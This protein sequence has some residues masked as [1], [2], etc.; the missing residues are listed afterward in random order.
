MLEF[1]FQI[2]Q[3]SYARTIEGSAS[4]SLQYVTPYSGLV[5]VLKFC[6]KQKKKEYLN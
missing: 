5:L 1:S 4:Y 3:Y 6:L 2:I